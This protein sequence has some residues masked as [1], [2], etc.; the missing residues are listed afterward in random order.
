MTGRFKEIEKRLLTSQM[1]MRGA[2]QPNGF[3][4]GIIDIF[5]R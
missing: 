2:V 5:G 3:I 4:W 1:I